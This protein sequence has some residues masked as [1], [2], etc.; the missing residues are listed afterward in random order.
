MGVLSIENL[1]L[2]KEKLPTYIVKLKKIQDALVWII[3]YHV[4]QE[5]GTYV[6]FSWMCIKIHLEG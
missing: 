1:Q 3:C 2:E 6:M 4:L 5:R